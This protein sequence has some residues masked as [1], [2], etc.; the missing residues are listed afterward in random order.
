LRLSSD[1][2]HSARLAGDAR[3]GLTGSPRTLPS[4][5]SYDARGSALFERRGVAAR[6]C[7]PAGSTWCPARARRWRSSRPRE[8]SCK[9]TRERV[10]HLFAG[11]GLGL[12]RW[13]TDPDDRFALALGSPGSLRRHHHGR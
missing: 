12:Q 13:D 9:F 10:A 11:A 2:D 5:S 3:R 4:D 6:R 1:G 7:V 8:T